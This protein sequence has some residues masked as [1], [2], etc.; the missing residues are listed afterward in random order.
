[1]YIIYIYHALIG[2]LHYIIQNHKYICVQHVYNGHECVD[3]YIYILLNY[4][5]DASL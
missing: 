3:A 1:M 2:V 4:H 5:C